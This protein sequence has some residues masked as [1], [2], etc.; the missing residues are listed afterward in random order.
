MCRTKFGM[1]EFVLMLNGVGVESVT[2]QLVTLPEVLHPTSEQPDLNVA[3]IAKYG[4]KNLC[5]DS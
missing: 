2:E 3:D 1:A 4:K 5:K